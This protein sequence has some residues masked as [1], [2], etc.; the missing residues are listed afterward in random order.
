MTTSIPPLFVYLIASLF[1]LFL[2][3][4]ALLA[5]VFPPYLQVSSPHGHMIAARAPNITHHSSVQIREEWVNRKVFPFKEKENF[6]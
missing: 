3:V 5:S 2:S 1:L 6:S 4:F